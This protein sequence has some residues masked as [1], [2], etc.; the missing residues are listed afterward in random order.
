MPK[1]SS[2]QQAKIKH[3]ERFLYIEL[4]SGDMEDWLEE[5]PAGQLCTKEEYET[6]I[7]HQVEEFDQVLDLFPY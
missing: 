6:H 2:I 4:A 7:P 5:N 3:G 1:K